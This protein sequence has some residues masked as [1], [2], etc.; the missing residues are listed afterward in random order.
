MK[1]EKFTTFKKGI[2][3]I[4]P[5]EEPID[6]LKGDYYIENILDIITDEDEIAKNEAA[7]V[8][9]DSLAPKNIKKGDYIWMTALLKK[10]G[11]ESYTS[12]SYTATIK[13][14]VDDI[15]NGLRNLKLAK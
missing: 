15:Y 12:Q 7:L 4:K 2:S 11:T 1:I 13:L 9:D 6:I 3:E 10:K 5:I 14:R 8:L